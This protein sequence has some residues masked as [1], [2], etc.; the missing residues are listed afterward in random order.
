M[1]KLL[2]SMLLLG[3]LPLTTTAQDDDMYFVPTKENRAKSAAT[4]GMP[5]DT[6][7]SGSNRS[8]D[9]Y[10]R[11]SWSSVTP[12]DSLGNDIIDFSAE[13]GVYPADTLTALAGEYPLTKRMSRFD[14]YTPGEAYW[15]GY[16]DGRWSS[17]WY[18]V[19]VDWYDPWYYSPWY[20]TSWSYWPS[21]WYY[22]GWYHH[23][24]HYGW[25]GYRG[26]YY[27][28]YRYVAYHHNYHHGVGRHVSYG[29]PRGFGSHGSHS[30]SA[31]TFGGSR[32]RGNSDGGTR[33]YTPSRPSGTSTSS[34]GN[35]GGSRGGG[36]FGGGGGGRSGGGGGGGHFGGRR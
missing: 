20:Y 16:R 28:P 13:Q 12:I 1:K 9:E 25:G 17:P 7:Y 31:G 10:N 8:V 15:Q 3:A 5:A 2:L 19:Y 33:S 24:W 14:D 35:F 22:T 36:G 32:V 21:S 26:W 23:P 6:Y 4:Y 27:R 30:Y 29:S 11:C 18:Y 34:F